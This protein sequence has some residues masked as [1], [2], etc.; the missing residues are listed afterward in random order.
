MLGDRMLEAVSLVPV[1]PAWIA[2][3]RLSEA[4]W[5]V[6]IIVLLMLAG[7]ASVRSMY[8]TRGRLGLGLAVGLAGFAVCAAAAFLPLL[9]RPG[10]W[11]QLS[12]VAPWILTFVLANGFAEELLFR[13]LFLRRFERFLGKGWSNLLAAGAFTLWRLQAA[14]V[15]ELAVLLLVLL[16]LALAWGWLMQ[17]TGSLWGSALFHAGADCLVIFGIDRSG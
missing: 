1:S 4:A 3:S 2:L 10:G 6:T 15:S 16:P 8:L 5:R 13:G 17:K 14:P 7:G 11:K 12:S 9:G